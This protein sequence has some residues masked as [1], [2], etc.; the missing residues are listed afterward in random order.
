MIGRRFQQVLQAIEFWRRKKAAYQVAFTGNG[1]SEVLADLA[2]FCHFFK[3]TAAPEDDR[4]A[5]MREGRRQV[6]LRIYHHLKLTPEQLSA[7]YLDVIADNG[8]T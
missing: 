1:G 8:E 4:L 7:L 3:T 2:D 5:A 6:F